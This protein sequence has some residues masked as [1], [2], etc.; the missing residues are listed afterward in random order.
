MLSPRS[1]KWGG[2]GGGT[3][4]FIVLSGRTCIFLY[5]IWS[6]ILLKLDCMCPLVL[7]PYA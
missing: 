6:G 7:G 3:S 4:K 1:E 5:L 2:G